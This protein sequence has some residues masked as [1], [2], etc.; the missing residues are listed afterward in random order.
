[1]FKYVSTDDIGQRIASNKFWDEHLRSA[2]DRV[3][4]GK[5]MVDIGANLGFFVVYLARKGVKVHAFEPC[6][7]VFEMLAD[8]VAL[9]GVEDMVTLHKTALYSR[10]TDLHKNTECGWTYPATSNG[11]LDFERIVNSGQLCL[12]PGFGGVYAMQG[13]TLDSYKLEDVAL[14][15]SDAQ[16]CDLQALRGA[17]ETIDRCKPILCFEFERIPSLVHGDTKASYEGFVEEIGYRIEMAFNPDP[18]R[19]DDYSDY[20]AVP[21]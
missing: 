2:M 5:V 10:E 9:N 12:K 18:C 15:K 21:K 4:P 3:E 6:N 1:M 13:K 17:R 20:V 14:I 8:N 11:E 19:H 16:G 7:G